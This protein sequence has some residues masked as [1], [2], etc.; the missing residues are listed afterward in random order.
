MNHRSFAGC[1][2][3]AAVSVAAAL[4]C[5]TAHA[6]ATLTPGVLSVGS[7]MTLPPHTYLDHGKPA[8]FD[9]EFVGKVASYMKDTTKFVDTR[10]ANLILGVTGGRYDIVASALY[11]TPERA[12]IVDFVPYFMTGGSIMV[13]SS[14]GL[15]P[16]TVGDLCGKR[17]GSIK[18]A[19]WIKYINAASDKACAAQG[20]PPVQVRE[21]ETSAET[22]QALLSQGIDAQYE[23]VSIAGL[24]VEKSGGRLKI[25]SNGP[26]DP[27][28][29]GL[30]MKK[31]NTELKSQIESAITQMK[32]KGEY[33]A[34]L[35]KY[36]VVAPTEAEVAKALGTTQ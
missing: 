8:G 29:C 26:L 3:L 4:A 11:V 19:A 16:K 35:K 10:F 1:L 31:G 32:A 15:N 30:A 2:K 6:A 24:I 36:N 25:T 20:K 7:D 33:Q 9:P 17:I 22:A 14:G 18:G 34:L 27:V 21:Y 28:V 12:K 5:G 23:D 13:S